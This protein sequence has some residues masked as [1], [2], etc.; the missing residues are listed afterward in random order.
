[1]RITKQ[2]TPRIHNHTNRS[3]RHIISHPNIMIQRRH[4][5]FVPEIII[6]RSSGCFQTS[7]GE[8]ICCW[9]VATS[10]V[11]ESVGWVDV[12][13]LPPDVI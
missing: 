5:P 1:M 4:I 6:F 10:D 13:P 12:L 2:P 8:I 9:E 7:G 11:V 3:I